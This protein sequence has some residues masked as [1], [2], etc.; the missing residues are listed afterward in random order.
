MPQDSLK[1]T[2]HPIHFI[3][4]ETARCMALQCYVIITDP[5]FLKAGDIFPNQDFV[6][7][8]SP[9]ILSQIFSTV[10]KYKS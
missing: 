2:K 6:Q 4:R 9:I 5:Y 10:H 3:G 8:L 1:H 7:I